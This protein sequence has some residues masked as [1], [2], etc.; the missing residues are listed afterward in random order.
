MYSDPIA[1]LLTRIRNAHSAGHLSVSVQASKSKERLLSVLQKEG[2]IHGYEPY[3][4]GEGKNYL[5]IALRYLKARQPVIKVIRR[6]SSPGRRVYVPVDK[7]PKS[8]GGL[9]TIIVSTSKG[10]LPDREARREGV[11]GELICEVF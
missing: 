5:K 9:G 1:D 6:L 10:L 2:Y 3:S 4:A 7:I 11:G 8:R